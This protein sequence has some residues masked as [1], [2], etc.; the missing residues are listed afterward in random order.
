MSYAAPGIG[1]GGDTGYQDPYLWSTDPIG[2][3]GGPSVSPGFYG[4]G[5]GAGTGPGGFATGYSNQAAGLGGTD[6]TGMGAGYNFDVSQQPILPTFSF[7]QPGATQQTSASGSSFDQSVGQSSPTSSTQQAQS[8]IPVSGSQGIGVS[9]AGAVSSG[10]NGLWFV[11]G[12]IVLY[13]VLYARKK[14]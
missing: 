2:G 14:Y 9:G 5:L 13:I 10:I 4:L 6:F 11:A 3:Q 8:A 7:A 12:I 1:P